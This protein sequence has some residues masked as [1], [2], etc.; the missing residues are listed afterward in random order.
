[1]SCWAS[2][3]PV[4][5]VMRI[6]GINL[7]ASLNIM[8]KVVYYVLIVPEREFGVYIPPFD[9]FFLLN[10]MW[11]SFARRAKLNLLKI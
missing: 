3:F 1:M 10:V 6:L 9:F 11:F 7:D 5:N 4:G 8:S 2:G